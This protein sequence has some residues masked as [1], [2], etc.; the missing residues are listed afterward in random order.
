MRRLATRLSHRGHR[1]YFDR[2]LSRRSG[3]GLGGRTHLYSED[4]S[5]EDEGLIGRS[6]RAAALRC[7]V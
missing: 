5:A 3:A 1:C 2:C 6:F 4:R 7:G